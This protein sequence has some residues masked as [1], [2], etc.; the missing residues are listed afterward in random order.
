MEEEIYKYVDNIYKNNC[1][2]YFKCE[3]KHSDDVY[4]SVANITSNINLDVL[5]EKE[6][7][8][9]F[10]KISDR[11][12]MIKE[13]LINELKYSNQ[14]QPTT[15]N[16]FSSLVDSCEKNMKYLLVKTLKKTHKFFFENILGDIIWKSNAN[17]YFEY[18][19]IYDFVIYNTFECHYINIHQF[20]E[21]IELI[22]EYCNKNI[23]THKLTYDIVN[24]SDEDESLSW[25]VIKCKKVTI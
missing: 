24:D 10:N 23:T 20:T 9:L 2:N 5:D 6:L 3:E 17:K 25:I 18:S 13:L 7:S 1:I 11:N 12:K 16:H 14:L 22:I 4:E 15:L 21:L 19:D 8:V